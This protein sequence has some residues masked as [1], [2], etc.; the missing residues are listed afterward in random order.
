MKIETY[1][2]PGEVR[3]LKG[4]NAVVLDVLRATTNIVLALNNGAKRV[5][6]VAEVEE[7][8]E[9]RQREAEVILGGERNRVLIPGF[10]LAN[11]PLEYTAAAVAG[12]TIVMTTTNGTVALKKAAGADRVLVGSLINMASLSERVQSEAKDLVIIC[13]GTK[14]KISL[15]DSLAAGYLISLLR[16]SSDYELDDFGI[17]ACNLYDFYSPHLERA[18]CCSENG[19]SLLSLGK[20][21]DI[22]WAARLNYCSLVPEM[23]DGIIISGR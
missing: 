18:L 8:Y 20:K 11:S 7:A 23:K 12:K 2:L 19:R 1:A 10:D 4:K 16:T 21:E 13:S 22:H 17:M 3:E 14:G 6:P 5:I 9:Y 15:E